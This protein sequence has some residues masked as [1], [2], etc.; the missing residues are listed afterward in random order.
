MNKGHLKYKTATLTLGNISS[1]A[2]LVL[3][4]PLWKGV[5]G[6]T[7]PCQFLQAPVPPPSCPS[8]FWTCQF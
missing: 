1:V 3:P 4:L 7:S 5:P 6:A 2:Q 8:P